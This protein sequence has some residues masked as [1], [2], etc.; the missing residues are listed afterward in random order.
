MT[1]V[2]R[3]F[4]QLLTEKVRNGNNEW[5]PFWR[6]FKT[7]ANVEGFE[8]YILHTRISARSLSKAYNIAIGKETD[9]Q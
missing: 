3:P 6:E 4:F 5:I 2:N 8:D 7:T 9:N 1:A